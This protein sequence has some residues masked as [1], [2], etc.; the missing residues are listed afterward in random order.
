MA[1]LWVW[2]VP[3]FYDATLESEGLHIFEHLIFLGTSTIF[4]WPILSPRENSRLGPA[5]A[6]AYLSAAMLSTGVLG[7]LITFAPV[8]TYTAYLHPHDSLGILETIRHS[9]GLTLEADQQFG[10][11][12]MWVPGGMIYLLA[13]MAVLARWYRAP[14][15]ENLAHLSAGVSNGI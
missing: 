7:I 14:E 1:A 9:W 5:A 13:I 8:R 11:L 12:L 15:S 10:G 2:H 3:R 6:F 4:W